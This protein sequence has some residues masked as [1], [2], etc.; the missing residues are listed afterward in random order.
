MNKPYFKMNIQLHALGAKEQEYVDVLGGAVQETFELEMQD[1]ADYVSKVFGVQEI[2]E[3]R[4]TVLGTGALGEM[5]EFDGE[6]VYEDPNKG[7]Q[8]TF[9]Q[10]K[11]NKGIKYPIEFATLYGRSKRMEIV[12]GTGKLT[13]AAMN[14]LRTHAVVPFNKGFTTAY[15]TPD[16][17]ALFATDHKVTPEA[18]DQSNLFNLELTPSNLSTL[19]NAMYQFKSDKGARLGVSPRML[20]VGDDNL[21]AAIKICKSENEAYTGNN[22]ANVHKYQ[23]LE[24]LHLPDIQGNVWFLADYKQ[25]MRHHRW[26]FAQRPKIKQFVDEDR[27][28]LKYKVTGLWSYG[29]TSFHFIAGSD[30]R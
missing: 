15:A 27:D 5:E 21:D 1:T 23:K 2:K 25:M 26:I 3:E 18:A 29:P 4:H 28:L 14:T 22:D 24:Y 11:Y 8:K 30:R 10:V 16:G 6:I 17:K 13:D 19:R 20:I 12:D 7:Y 9:V